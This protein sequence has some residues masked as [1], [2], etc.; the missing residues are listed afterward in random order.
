MKN[1][2]EDW[3]NK[4]LSKLLISVGFLWLVLAV[5][6]LIFQIAFPQNV[7]IT[8][9]T[10]T[11]QK[12]AGFNLYRRNLRDNQYELVNKDRLISNVGDP[13]TGA[14]YS[15]VDRDVTPGMTYLY[16]LEEVELDS[17]RNRYDQDVFEFTI[18]TFS[19]Q[20]ITLA[21][22]CLIVG[23]LLLLS[24]LKETISL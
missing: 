2:L 15:Y 3:S 17:T 20:Y 19:W 18:P 11:E 6:L 13:V 1:Y 12:T 24:G 4:N 14:V 10:A 23:L 22:I 9:E 5:S 8:W 21:S 16:V 7:E